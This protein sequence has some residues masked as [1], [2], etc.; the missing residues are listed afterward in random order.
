MTQAAQI[1]SI[2]ECNAII[3]KWQNEGLTTREYVTKTSSYLLADPGVASDFEEKISRSAELADSIT[4]EFFRTLLA[5]I[6]A[7]MQIPGLRDK[8]PEWTALTEVISGFMSLWI[9]RGTYFISTFLAMDRL[10][11]PF[12]PTRNR[13]VKHAFLWVRDFILSPPLQVFLSNIDFE[14]ILGCQVEN[15]ATEEDRLKAIA[16]L[17]C[18]KVGW[19]DN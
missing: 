13:A 17:E 15:I 10:L 8:I 19:N 1:L 11:R 6:V 9:Q 16:A 3:L 5:L 12:H 7:S 14:T 4:E 18:F 2:D